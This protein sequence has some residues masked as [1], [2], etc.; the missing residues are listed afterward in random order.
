VGS[1]FAY[2]RLDKYSNFLAE[3]ADNATAQA[4]N[5]TPVLGDY[6]RNGDHTY[7]YWDGS[8]WVTGDTTRLESYVPSVYLGGPANTETV[9]F[10]IPSNVPIRYAINKGEYYMQMDEL[11]SGPNGFTKAIATHVNPAIETSR[12]SEAGSHAINFVVGAPDGMGTVKIFIPDTLPDDDMPL[13]YAILELLR[14]SAGSLEGALSTNNPGLM[15]ITSSSV[16]V[17]D[18]AVQ[19]W[20]KEGLPTSTRIHIPAMFTMEN[21]SVELTPT[22]ANGNYV[23]HE[24]IVKNQVIGSEIVGH[25]NANVVTVDGE[26]QDLVTNKSLTQLF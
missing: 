12:M 21:Y 14:D 25:V 6:Y 22:D 20:P 11:N 5:L 2:M 3:Y 18:N 17:L 7:G 15:D 24:K 19:F 1:A 26:P 10:K 8:R 16:K 9:E 4:A 23:T 13:G